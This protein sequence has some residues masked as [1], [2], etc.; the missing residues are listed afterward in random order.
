MI[1]EQTPPR[2]GPYIGAFRLRL[3]IALIELSSLRFTEISR[4]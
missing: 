1:Q 3:F 2:L 4:A